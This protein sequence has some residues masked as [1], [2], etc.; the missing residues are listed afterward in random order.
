MKDAT[1]VDYLLG[2]GY[3]ATYGN[4]F[5]GNYVQDFVDNLTN[6]NQI[7]ILSDTLLSGTITNDQVVP[8]PSSVVLFGGASLALGIAAFVRRRKAR[9]TT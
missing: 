7:P 4:Y 9:L 1:L 6:P 2:S 3:S 8:E 5:T